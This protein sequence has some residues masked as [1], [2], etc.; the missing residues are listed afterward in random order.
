[1]GQAPAEGY[2]KCMKHTQAKSHNSERL[3]S[4]RRENT[5]HWHNHLVERKD[6]TIWSCTAY[7]SHPSAVKLRTQMFYR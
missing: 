2:T 5:Q 3:Q 1:M 6:G 4:N 7:I